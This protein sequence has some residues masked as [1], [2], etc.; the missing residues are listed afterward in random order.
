MTGAIIDIAVTVI[1]LAVLVALVVPRIRERR[2][3]DGQTYHHH[4]YHEVPH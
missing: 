3:I 1:V 2:R 4:G